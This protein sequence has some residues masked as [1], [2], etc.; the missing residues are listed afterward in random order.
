M[1]GE[2]PGS[3]NMSGLNPALFPPPL[4]LMYPFQR[5]AAR[6]WAEALQGTSTLVIESLVAAGTVATGLEKSSQWLPSRALHRPLVLR[7][8]GFG[9][10]AGSAGF[11]RCVSACLLV[12]SGTVAALSTATTS[13]PPTGTAR[14]NS[15]AARFS[16]ESVA[17]SLLTGTVARAVGARIASAA[18]LDF[19]PAV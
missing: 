16:D 5:A 7:V 12:W 17:R 6:S 19:P 8:Y 2:C 14:C 11:V 15:A 4:A 3:F 9:H 13:A 10:G 18:R 1:Y